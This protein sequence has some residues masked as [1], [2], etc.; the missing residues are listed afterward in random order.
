MK[1]ENIHELFVM[2]LKDLYSAEK[3]LVQALPK[4]AEAASNETLKQGFTDH[5]KQTE[6]HVERLEKI[7]ENLD[8]A[9]GGHACK[10]MQGLIEEGSEVIKMEGEAS[11]KDVAL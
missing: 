7:A 6:G 3:Q 9:I 8:F 4:M 10:A 11:V 1:L 5:L 2:Q